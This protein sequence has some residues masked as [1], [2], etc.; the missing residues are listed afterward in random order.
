N[1]DAFGFGP[2]YINADRTIWASVP[3]AGWSAGGDKVMWIRPAG[4]DLVV[5]GRRLDGEAP[6]LRADIPCC[7]PT[8]FQAS[9]LIFPTGGCWE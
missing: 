1:A 7:Y 5:S 9:G 6:P 8:G 3:R 4:S 2:W